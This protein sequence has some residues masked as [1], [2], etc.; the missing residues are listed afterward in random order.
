MHRRELLSLLAAPLV[1]AAVLQSQVTRTDMHGAVWGPKQKIT[2]DEAL[3][4]G[5][6]HGAYA[7]FEEASKGSIEPGKLADLVVLGRDP[8]T[9]DPSTLVSIPVE[10]TMVGGRWVWES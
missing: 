7:S 10:R 5:T 9:Q 8:R 2:I 4:V 1:R 6:L 3:R